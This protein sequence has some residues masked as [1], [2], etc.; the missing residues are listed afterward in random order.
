MSGYTI[1]SSG[2]I[3]ETSKAAPFRSCGLYRSNDL[4]TGFIQPTAHKCSKYLV[5]QYKHS[6]ASFKGKFKFGE[7]SNLSLYDCKANCSSDCSC[8]AF[9]YDDQTASCDVWSRGLSS[10]SHPNFYKETTQLYFMPSDNRVVSSCS[11][12]YRFSPFQRSI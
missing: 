5:Q 7:Y 9:A 4:P 3:L 8:V 2:E 11:D 12:N 6:K 10:K 1:T